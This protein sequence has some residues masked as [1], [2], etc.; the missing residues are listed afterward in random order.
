M[1]AFRILSACTAVVCAIVLAACGGSNKQENAKDTEETKDAVRGELGIFELQGPVKECTV[2]YEWGDVVRTFD[3]DGFWLTH[4]GEPLSDVYPC[5]I[6]R[7]SEGRI[8]AGV[9]DSDGN[10]DDYTYDEQGRVTRYH[11]HYFDDLSTETTT[12]DEEGNITKRHYEFG[13][14]DMIEPYDET[15]E[16][17]VVDDHGNWTERKVTSTDGSTTTQTRVIVYY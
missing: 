5:G 13:G 6:T 12:Y 4:N 7:D 16:N 9:T 3:E 14:V 10:G 17:T 11:A 1:K 2:K 15:Y 8:T